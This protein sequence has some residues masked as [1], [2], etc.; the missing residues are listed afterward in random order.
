M[1]APPKNKTLLAEDFKEAPPWFSKLLTP[2]NEFMTAVTNALTGRLTRTE[3]LLGYYEDF[4]FTTEST[5]A[6]TFPLRFKNKLLG[7]VR[8]KSVVV[9][10]IKKHD[11]IAM[12][13][14]YSIEWDLNQS[15]E[16]EVIFTGLENSKRYVGTMVFD[17]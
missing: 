11:A 1:A 2:L 14:A 6:N 13:A 9:G 12:S 5:A 16:I 17:A 7:G 4:D 15:G 10:R 8:P 3:N